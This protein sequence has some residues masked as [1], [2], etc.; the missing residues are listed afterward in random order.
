MSNPEKSKLF[1]PWTDP[2]TGVTVYLLTHKVAPVQEAFY[3]VNNSMTADGR[4]LW[5]Y[6][7]FPPSGS[8]LYGRT[9]G[10]VDFEQ[11]EV[12]HFPETQF[13]SASPLADAE[14]GEV[15][16]TTGP[17]IWKRP[18]DPTAGAECVNSLPQ[19]IVGNRRI[20]R[21]ATHLSLSADGKEFFVDAA[22]GLQWVFGSLP[23]DG[24]DFQLW[25]RF[26]RHHNH[27]QFSP[28]D[29][30]LVLFA[31]ENHLDPITGLRI[32]IV[33]RMWLIRRGK[34]PCPVFDTPTRVTHEWWDV[35]GEHVWCVWDNDAWRTNIETQE[36]EKVSWPAH[37]WHA[38]ISR[39]GDYMISDSNERFYRGCPSSVY[40]LNR[41]TG[42]HVHILSNPE[43]KGIV[44]A[45]YHVDPHPRFC[46]SDKLAVF[47]T[48]VRGEVDLAVAKVDDLID[49]TT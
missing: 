17:S 37:C 14:S 12:H 28:T 46:G 34:A 21:L 22:F 43:M 11:Q 26:D 33:D 15:Y 24:G 29:P 35:D 39:D 42:K 4:Y 3:F 9:L 41:R 44:G 25:H 13:Q 40:F 1:S 31:E 10:V 6:C 20:H 8:Q 48:T 32:P 30:D 49:R 38:H 23:V 19:E 16:W 27:A 18:A 5:F 36:V 45:R 2:E 7:A 47:T